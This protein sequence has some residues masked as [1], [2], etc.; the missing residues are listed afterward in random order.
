MVSNSRIALIVMLAISMGLPIRSNAQ[1][2]GA[3]GATVLATLPAGSTNLDVA[4]TADGKFLY[5]LD[6]G[7]GVVSIFRIGE[8]GLLTSLGEVGNLRASSGL[9]GIAAI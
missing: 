9:N 7:T 1:G 8:D 5:S 2:T 6:S 3:A 4:I